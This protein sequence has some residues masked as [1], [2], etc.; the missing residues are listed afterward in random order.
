MT[1]GPRILFTRFPDVDGAKFLP[2][3]EHASRVIG[4]AV[5]FVPSDEADDDSSA[6]VWSLVGGNNRPLAR[7]SRAFA[8]FSDAVGDAQ[9]T[10]AHSADLEVHLVSDRKRGGHGWYFALAGTPE[11]TCSR[12]YDSERDRRNAIDVASV[13]LVNA[14]VRAGA[15]L[16]PTLFTGGLRD[17]H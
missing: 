11:L 5:V 17:R 10:V 4:A 16:V 2:W 13:S 7:G 3:R 12:W 15:R 1:V 14:E 9:N 6:V 8:R